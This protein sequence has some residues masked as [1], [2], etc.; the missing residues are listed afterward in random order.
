M[1]FRV[2]PRLFRLCLLALLALASPSVL[3]AAGDPTIRANFVDHSF[4][5]AIEGNLNDGVQ[6]IQGRGSGPDDA[7][8][9]MAAA[10]PAANR[11]YWT[12]LCT[13]IARSCGTINPTSVSTQCTHWRTDTNTFTGYSVTNTITSPA[14]KTVDQS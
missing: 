3:A 11:S 4:W 2:G 1:S 12:Y 5:T 7:N 14:F 13:A 8:A 10:C 9:S 6:S